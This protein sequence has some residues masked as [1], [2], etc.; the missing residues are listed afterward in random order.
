MFAFT[1]LNLYATEA[2]IQ[3]CFAKT[4][5]LKSMR[6]PLKIPVKD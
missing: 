1:L 3:M 2:A 4:L 5:F 6:N